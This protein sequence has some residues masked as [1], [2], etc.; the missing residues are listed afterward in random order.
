MFDTF[1]K[2]QK[3]YHVKQRPHTHYAAVEIFNFLHFS[4]QIICILLDEIVSQNKKEFQMRDNMLTLQ[5]LLYINILFAYD[6]PYYFKFHRDD[7]IFK[8]V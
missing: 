5:L 4:Q 3:E 1:I 6:L 2:I 7:N 8:T